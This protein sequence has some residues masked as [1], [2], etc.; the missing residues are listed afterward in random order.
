MLCRSDSSCLHAKYFQQ[1]LI[2]SSSG[3]TVWS[4]S[5]DFCL[6]RECFSPF[7]SFS[8]KKNYQFSQSKRA[9]LFRLKTTAS[10]FDVRILVG[11]GCHSVKKGDPLCGDVENFPVPIALLHCLYPKKLNMCTLVI[12][13]KFISWHFTNDPKLTIITDWSNTSSVCSCMFSVYNLTQPCEGGRE[14][15]LSPPHISEL[16]RLIPEVCLV[17]CLSAFR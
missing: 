4:V 1:F 7:E 6:Y 17:T 9:D 14:K 10:D 16:Q 3:K 13:F 2:K 5:C 12:F 11:G 15:F 8:R